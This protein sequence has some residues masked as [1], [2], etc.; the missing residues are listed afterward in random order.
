MGSTLRLTKH[1]SLSFIE[2][3]HKTMSP[4]HP[5]SVVVATRRDVDL[6]Y[7]VRNVIRRSETAHR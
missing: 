6:E 5:P 4:T 3:H 1:D 2:C 7:G